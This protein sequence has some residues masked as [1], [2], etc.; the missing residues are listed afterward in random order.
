MRRSL[1]ASRA[2]PHRHAG[3]DCADVLH[4]D[5]LFC[6][7]CFF[8]T[9]RAEVRGCILTIWSMLRAVVTVLDITTLFWAVFGAHEI[10]PPNILPALPAFSERSGCDSAW[11]SAAASAAPLPALCGGEVCSVHLLDR[12]IHTATSTSPCD[13]LA[14]AETSAC[15]GATSAAT[16]KGPRSLYSRRRLG[17]LFRRGPVHSISFNAD[18]TGCCRRLGEFSGG[19]SLFAARPSRRATSTRQ[20]SCDD[21]LQ[22]K[23][24][25]GATSS[26]PRK[27]PRS[28]DSR[29]RLRRL[30]SSLLS[31]SKS[32]PTQPLPR[33]CAAEHAGCSAVGRVLDVPFFFVPPL[34]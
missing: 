33:W 15:G 8:R 18:A 19:F 9:N 24:S 1:A 22:E 34:S 12:S 21:T 16:R 7:C 10:L 25:G 14:V 3:V 26:A 31:T 2:L 17:R 13:S 20:A 32:T 27:G 6:I 28:L 30:L 5:G 11:A 29:R 4:F 23:L